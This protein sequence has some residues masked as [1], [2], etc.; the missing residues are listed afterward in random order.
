MPATTP[1]N[2][3]SMAVKNIRPLRACIL[4][5][6]AV[7]A[8]LAAFILHKPLTP[9]QVPDWNPLFMGYTIIMLAA[10]FAL[11]SLCVPLLLI[12]FSRTREKMRR[13]FF[14]FAT[15]AA[16]SILCAVALDAVMSF[17]PALEVWNNPQPLVGP[18]APH[19]VFDKELGYRF[20][21]DQTLKRRYSAVKDGDLISTGQV[22]NP[23]FTGEIEDGMEFTLH[24]DGNG[25]RNDSVPEKCDIFVVGD[26]YAVPPAPFDECWTTLVGK[27][28]GMTPYNGGL[29]GFSFQ[30]EMGVL[31]RY[32]A[33]MR[34]RFVLWQYFQGN[35]L[36]EA[37]RFDRYLN[38]GEDYQAFLRKELNTEKPFPYNRP[39][40]RLLAY[41]L[42]AGRLTTNRALVDIG[43]PYPGPHEIVAGGVK[44]PIA[45]NKGFFYSLCLP[46]KAVEESKGWR[47]GK[48]CLL[49]ANALCKEQDACLVVVY[50]PAKLTVFLHYALPLFDR[51][52]IWE[53]ARPVMREI[54][55]SGIDAETFLRMLDENRN[56]QYEALREF[57]DAHNITL[58]DTTPALLASLE[59]GRW[60][61]YCYDAHM[62]I[63]GQ[64]V[65]A[66]VVS[67]YLNS[68][69]G[70]A[71]SEENA[72]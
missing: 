35:D 63:T 51:R 25:F 8:L 71:P 69:T 66:E 20:A 54:A 39:L 33:G 9:A 61:Y 49:E 13:R 48:G 53:F 65:V 56:A 64:H 37:E 16:A 55:D 11:V 43:Q 67:S 12:A 7:F 72:P 15:F 58:I 59:K 44:K 10:A 31:K 38:S 47:I 19:C 50:M 5:S 1:E 3:K 29:P 28:T 32:G 27:K 36:Y 70:H 22:A 14:R 24:T 30:Q 21:P 41:L 45:F 40:L 23:I 46:R 34:P 62:N 6:A 4:I 68:L 2:D 26:S 60:P 17:F 42:G 57:C 18:L 52:K